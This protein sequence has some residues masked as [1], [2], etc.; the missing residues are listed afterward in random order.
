MAYLLY[1]WLIYVFFNLFAIYI[2]GS[3]AP[4]TFSTTY[5]LF[6][7]YLLCLRLILLVCCL[8]FIRFVYVYY[9]YARSSTNLSGFVSTMPMP[10]LSTPSI[11]ASTMSVSALS[12]LSTSM[13]ISTSDIHYKSQSSIF[14]LN[15]ELINL[16]LCLSWLHHFLH[17]SLYYVSL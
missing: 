3:S 12:A 5:L 10:V 6:V 9:A 15:K 17:L 16:V 7:S 2:P 4:P 8:G 1:L 13:S 14:T 11:F